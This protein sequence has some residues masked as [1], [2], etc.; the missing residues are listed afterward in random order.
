MNVENRIGNPFS[1]EDSCEEEDDDDEED[2]GNKEEKKESEISKF[3]K[4]K[5]FKS[6]TNNWRSNR[7]EREQFLN[8]QKVRNQ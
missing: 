7:H 6:L 3:K 8:S 2:E 4:G 1:D 5:I